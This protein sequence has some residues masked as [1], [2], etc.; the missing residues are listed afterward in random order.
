[1]KISILHQ[2]HLGV[3]QDLYEKWNEWIKKIIQ[4][5]ILLLNNNYRRINEREREREK[6]LCLCAW[7][8]VRLNTYS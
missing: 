4:E 5:L 2:T 3:S 8:N 1:M 6:L 7:H